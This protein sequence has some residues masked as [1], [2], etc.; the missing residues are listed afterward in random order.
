[1]GDEKMSQSL[2]SIELSPDLAAAVDRGLNED[3]RMRTVL[4]RSHVASVV[5]RDEP[6]VRVALSGDAALARGL[7]EGGVKVLASFPGAPA[8]HYP[9]IVAA[10]SD[11][12][13]IHVEWSMSEKVAFEVAAA[14]AISGVRSCYGGK[15]I[16]L[17]V[18]ADTIMQF[19]YGGV[20]AGMVMIA[21][22][23]VGAY[24]S[25]GEFDCRYYTPMF[26]FPGMDPAD[27]QE[28]KD[29]VVDAF[30]ASEVSKLPVL[31]LVTNEV[32]WRYSGVT[33]GALPPAGPVVR[34]PYDPARWRVH[35]PMVQQRK[36]W[37]RAQLAQVQELAE[38]SRFNRLEQR[39][40]E[41]VGVITIG[42][43]SNSVFEVKDR[44]GLSDVAVL[45]IG[46]FHPLPENLIRSFVERL[47]RVLVVEFLEPF[48]EDQVR[49]ML[50]TVDRRVELLGKRSGHLPAE[51][52]FTFDLVAA[53]LARLRGGERTAAPRADAGIR[54]EILAAVPV[55]RASCP[56]CP[57]RA[58]FYALKMAL[59]DTGKDGFVLVDS[60]CASSAGTTMG[61]GD[62]KLNLG[63]SLGLSGGLRMA[64]I[65]D[66]Q[67][68]ACIGDSAFLHAGLPPLLNLVQNDVDGMVVVMD[69][70]C[71]AATGHQPSASA[72]V[73]GDGRSTTKADFA[74]LAAACNVDHVGTTD[75]YDQT[76]ARETFVRALSAPPG[77][78]VVVSSRECAYHA[79]TR[80]KIE[81]EE[82]PRF[83]V[84]DSCTSDK[85]CVSEFGC[86][87]IYLKV[88]AKAA[89]DPAL[90]FGCGVCLSVCDN[91]GWA[92]AS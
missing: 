91:F 8:C 39:G 67:V 1:M 92:A 87:A 70:G 28:A 68:I 83:Y 3:L 40:D 31:L 11:P 73:T 6:G 90:C 64:G 2:A 60:G 57:H 69:N 30:T 35:G 36:K 61:I 56:G 74:E 46:Y 19:C 71:N 42:A 29:M 59:R 48:V 47:D 49:Q 66:K 76:A 34:A 75:P 44:L 50:A 27:P 16:G 15:D 54:K 32:G 45:K 41:R 37:R 65:E 7:L 5:G 62:L 9:D 85:K 26:G 14:A 4:R 21:A 43:A 20:D 55:T 88:D 78:R 13:G 33:L 22:T 25:S 18:A 72:G 81:G 89:I 23:D 79:I 12:L 84:K 53:A 10:F 24:V 52:F 77:Q 17:N 86:P 51:G 80:R 82:I 63:S 38:R 58:T